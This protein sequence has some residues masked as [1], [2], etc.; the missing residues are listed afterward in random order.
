MSDHSKFLKSVAQWLTEFVFH[1]NWL[2]FMMSSMSLNSRN[3]SKYL[4]KSLKH[5]P[6]RLNLIYLTPNN[7]SKSWI[8]RR[9]SPEERK[10]RCIRSYGIITPKKKQLGKLNLIFNEISQ[11]SFKPIPKSN[12]SIPFCFRISRRDSF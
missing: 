10:L 1:L 2:L 12:C 7:L 4:L 9:V 3:V 5:K 11:T 8:P 6:L